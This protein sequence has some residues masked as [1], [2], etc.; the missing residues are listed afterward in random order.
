MNG[1]HASITTSVDGCITGPEDGPGCGLGVG[2][3][4]LH[5]WVFGGA[6]S[7]DSGVRGEAVGEDRAWLESTMAANGAVI[8]GRGTYES[9]G[10]WGDKNPWDVPIF[11]V[12]HRPDE[13]PPGGEFVFVGGLPQAVERAREVAG[14]KQVHVMGGAQVIRQALAGGFVDRLT[15]VIAPVVLGAGKR[16]FEGFDGSL[17]LEHVGVRQ[18]P[19]ATFVDYR[20]RY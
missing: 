6:W 2:G 10:H 3:E 15:I 16:L 19:F 11:V 14:D 13:Q 5:Y 12:T 18:S 20:V 1:V 4:R 17:E 7:Y 9:A 8:C